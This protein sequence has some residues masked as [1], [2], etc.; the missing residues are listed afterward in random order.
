[1][2]KTL[3]GLQLK[4]FGSGSISLTAQDVTQPVVKGY[5]AGE[6]I[7]NYQNPIGYYV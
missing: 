2:V 7:R 6:V 5:N 3:L 4:A 1:M